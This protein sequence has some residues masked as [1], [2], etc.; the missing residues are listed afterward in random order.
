MNHIRL[1]KNTLQQQLR[2]TRADLV[3][4]RSRCNLPL[5]DGGLV[6]REYSFRRVVVWRA[7]VICPCCLVWVRLHALLAPV[8]PALQQEASPSRWTTRA[9][10]QHTAATAQHLLGVERR[11]ILLIHAR[12]ESLLV[13]TGHRPC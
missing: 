10:H 9:H 8:C 2:G 5:Q 3:Q 7:T 12:V 11:V 6:S 1:K 4:L 13:P